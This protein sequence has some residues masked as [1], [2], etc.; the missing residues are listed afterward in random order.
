[1][2]RISSLV[3]TGLGIAALTVV[4][5]QHGAGRLDLARAAMRRYSFM[6]VTGGALMGLVFA[7]WPAP[8]IRLF[9][10]DPAVV[11]PSRGVYAG[12]VRFDGEEYA[13]CTNIGVAPTFARAESRMEA[14]LLDFQG[15]LY[16]KTVDV[17]FVRRIREEMRFSGVGELREQISRDVEQARR[18]MDHTI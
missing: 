13:A 18:I 14:H 1:M 8:L 15:D 12:F 9:S 16:G 17:G 5:Q 6:A 7:I 4:G 10:P 2:Q 11:V 3:Y